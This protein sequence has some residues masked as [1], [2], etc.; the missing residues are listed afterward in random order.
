MVRGRSANRRIPHSPAE[1]GWTPSNQGR[2]TRGER[3]PGR[4][5][6]DAQVLHAHVCHPKSL[7]G[8][9]W[10][11][12][13]NK[14][15]EVPDLLWDLTGHGFFSIC[16]SHAPLTLFYGN[17]QIEVHALQINI[18][19]YRT[20]M[21]GGHDKHALPANY[22]AGSS[23]WPF[24]RLIVAMSFQGK[25]TL[26]VFAT[27]PYKRVKRT[28]SSYCFSHV[29]TMT[30]RNSG[31]GIAYPERDDEPR[32]KSYRFDSAGPKRHRNDSR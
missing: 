20:E 8:C 9:N 5:R 21:F 28:A 3:N 18:Q 26:A 32:P 1:R 7:L 6:S 31:V 27:R 25:D 10:P 2:F 22:L 12:M 23:F 15:A 30:P 24:K 4:A 17:R 19:L 13:A 11:R 14:R 29:F 16:H